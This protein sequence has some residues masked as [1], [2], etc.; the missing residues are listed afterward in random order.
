[1]ALI[2]ASIS[3]KKI[4]EKQAN[5]AYG[6]TKISEGHTSLSDAKK[7]KFRHAGHRSQGATN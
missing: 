5:C 4:T 1:M 2:S 6:S 7:Q 3:I